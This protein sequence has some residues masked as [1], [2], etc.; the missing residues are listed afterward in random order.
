MGIVA[1]LVYISIS[2]IGHI[3]YNIYFRLFTCQYPPKQCKMLYVNKLMAD[4]ECENPRLPTVRHYPCTI[5]GGKQ[6]VVY[7]HFPRSI[8][9]MVFHKR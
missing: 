8:V 2:C 3:V 1:C 4:I 5:V 9:Q 7:P 6:I